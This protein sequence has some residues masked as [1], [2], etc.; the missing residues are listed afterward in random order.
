VRTVVEE[1]SALAGDVFVAEVELEEP[2]AN[3][4]GPERLL[5]EP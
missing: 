4:R 3:Q 5:V 1:P 2:S